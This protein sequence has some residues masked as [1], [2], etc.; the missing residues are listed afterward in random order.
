MTVQFKSQTIVDIENA[1]MAPP[2]W[3][4]PPNPSFSSEEEHLSQLLK[5]I[6]K[7][8]K[9]TDE[10][11]YFIQYYT[12]STKKPYVW[13]RYDAF[14]SVKPDEYGDHYTHAKSE[15]EKT[16]VTYG[17]TGI[18]VVAFSFDSLNPMYGAKYLKEYC[19]EIVAVKKK[20]YINGANASQ[21]FLAKK[22]KMFT[23]KA[24][25]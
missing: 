5:E 2:N 7:T 21:E 14:N 9:Q 25:V 19:F 16:R 8:P 12:T 17:W 6:V 15:L 13:E 1:P 4:P 3:Q 18:K 20:T 22:G 24:G 11:G 23:T 10:R